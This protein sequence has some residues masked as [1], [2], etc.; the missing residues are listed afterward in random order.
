MVVN[1]TIIKKVGFDFHWDE[2]K[3]WK[4]KI[5]KE[6]MDLAKLEWMFYIP[7]WA[8]PKGPAYSLKP[9]DVIKH[10]KKYS[11]EYKRTM[12]ANLKHPLDIMRNKGR[13]LMLDGLH[14]CVKAKILGYKE[15]YV[16]KIP[17]SAI[18]SI[19]P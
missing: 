19:R 17:R 16:R 3:V 8:L 18:K 13:W 5:K 12:Q 10:P 6:K 7:F 2:S 9:I 1:P 4:L 15:I 11:K 14:R